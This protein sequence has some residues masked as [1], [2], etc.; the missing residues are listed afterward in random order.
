MPKAT[1]WNN[2][3]GSRGGNPST[4]NMK[5]KNTKEISAAIRSTPFDNKWAARLHSLLKQKRQLERRGA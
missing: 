5:P 2:I 4:N 3:E 1:G